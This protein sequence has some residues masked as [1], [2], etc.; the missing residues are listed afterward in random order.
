VQ[1]EWLPGT[2]DLGLLVKHT[3]LLVKHTVARPADPRSNHFAAPLLLCSFFLK[4]E[5]PGL[6]CSCT[7]FRQVAPIIDL[8][9]CGSWPLFLSLSH[10]HTHTPTHPPTH[11]PTQSLSLSL[12]LTHTHTHT[13]THSHA[14]RLF[15]ALARTVSHPLF[16]QQLSAPELPCPH[17][18]RTPPSCAD[19][20][21]NATQVTFY[22]SRDQDSAA[23]LFIAHFWAR[24]YCAAPLLHQTQRCPERHGAFGEVLT[25]ILARSL[26]DDIVARAK[27][28]F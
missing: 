5:V 10:T 3:G 2:T 27:S 23:A 18:G 8:K 24:P 14:Q 22:S 26:L 17:A 25:S 11:P 1:C 28:E 7:R 9:H 15:K 20:A 12:S 13:H 16:R 6:C 19:P 4:Q 21:S